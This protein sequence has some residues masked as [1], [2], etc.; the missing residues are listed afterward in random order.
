MESRPFAQVV[1]LHTGI[2]P[3]RKRINF[4]ESNN[5]RL[6]Y[7]D[8]YR[9]HILYSHKLLKEDN[10]LLF[11]EDSILTYDSLYELLRQEKFH[12]EIQKI[13]PHFF[14]Q[15]MTYLTEK[16]SVLATQET[17]HTSF[18]AATVQKTRKQIENIHKMIKELYERRESKIIQMALFASRIGSEMQEKHVL[19]PLEFQL[20]R[21]LTDELTL[22]RQGILHNVLTG[23]KPDVIREK[24]FSG[25]KKEQDFR[26]IRFL[27]SVPRFVSEDL[28]S[29]G[30]YNE[31]D[32]ALLP[33][34][35]SDVLV[36]RQHAEL[37]SSR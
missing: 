11:M 33:S 21:A 23:K 17:K 13:E 12:K 32:V 5:S 3:E 16:K 14:S 31:E 6:R 8:L 10:K 20:Y 24:L 18:D 22:F 34:P 35:L 4:F 29:Y 9:I 37:I 1:N 28:A 19:L 7:N 25:Q 36:S 15:V 27:H 26:L 2:I 30:P